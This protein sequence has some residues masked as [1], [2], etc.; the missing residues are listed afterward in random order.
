LDG[1]RPDGPFIGFFR[2]G[3]EYRWRIHAIPAAYLTLGIVATAC[4]FLL[5]S[6][7]VG[8]AVVF[9][10]LGLSSVVAIL[11]GVARYR[12]HRSLPW[13]LFAAGQ[14]AFVV[15]DA[16]FNFYELALHMESPFPSVADGLYLFGYLPLIVALLILM[17]ARSPGQE[18][19]AL[20]DA[21]IVAVSLG[22]LSWLFL[23]VPY[24]HDSTLSVPQRLISIAYPFMDVL[25]IGVAV[26]LFVTGGRR[27]P[28]FNLVI[29]G[30]VA[31]L[32]ADIVYS[33][34][35][36][37]DTY[38]S[39][40]LVDA[41]WLV[42]YVL[43][44]AA[45]LH[46]SMRKLFELIPYRTP[47][48]KRRRIALLA[49][50]SLMPPAV[51]A[52]QA[53]RGKLLDAPVIAGGSAVLVLLVIAHMASLV[54]RIT[55]SGL[56]SLTGLPSQEPLTLALRAAAGAARH[57]RKSAL[58]YLDLHR[59]AAVND[60]LGRHAGD[61][62]LA[63]VASL[64]DVNVR[65]EDLVVR[66]GGDE[67]A[68]CRATPSGDRRASHGGGRA[69]RRSRRQHRHRNHRPQRTRR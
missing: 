23:M 39:G 49:A 32:A 65:E 38:R 54:R 3:D 56:D 43:W 60:A 24:A 12:P 10:A 40:L 47:K 50:A 55:A 58:L 61:R 11:A 15:G 41:G 67:F 28:S 22:M 63:A 14:L 16:I 45:G 29:L 1:P 53:A 34:M 5:P 42:S 8:Q 48:V 46:P 20:I 33:L 44:G 64:L 37:A 69:D 7:G 18:R 31:L 27:T 51:L 26:R 66:A 21:A 9:N 17:G 57:D 36:L 25:L 62:A 4:Y 68:T 19:S 13:Y 59:F 52:V 30:I 35:T 6:G 2:K